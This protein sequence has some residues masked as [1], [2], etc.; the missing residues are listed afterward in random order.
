MTADHNAAAT[1]EERLERLYRSVIEKESLALCGKDAARDFVKE[2]AGSVPPAQGEVLMGNFKDFLT[3][4]GSPY[5]VWK[6]LRGLVEIVDRQGMG[7]LIR[8][9]NLKIIGGGHRDFTDR[10]NHETGAARRVV[11]VAESPYFLILREAMYLRRNGFK[12]HLATLWPISEKLRPLFENH[13][14]SIADTAG[15]IPLLR[16]LLQGLRPDLFHVQCR[17]WAYYLGRM[18]IEN[19]GDAGVVCEFYDITSLFAS[20]E[21]LAAVWSA[22]MADLD[23]GLERYML[24]KADGVLSRFPSWIMAEWAERHE[25]E[26]LY[27]EFQSYPCTEFSDTGGARL[28]NDD[29]VIRLVFAGGL[30]PIDENHPQFLFPEVGMLGAFRSFLEQG[31][32]LDILHNPHMDRTEEEQAFAQY[33]D[34][35]NSYPRFRILNGVPPDRLAAALVPYDFGILLFDYDSSTARLGEFHK[36]GVVG[37]KIFSYLEAG[38]PVLVNTEYEHMAS[39]VTEHGLGLAVHSSDIPRLAETLAA[40]DLDAAAAN[41]EKY[42]SEHG[43]EREIDRLIGFYDR[44]LKEKHNA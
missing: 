11:F 36:R 15:N 28:S 33:H 14:N 27:M 12:V 8:R 23:I 9:H 25:A 38:L 3:K 42:N 24:H 44:I 34:L 29:S 43:M 6:S 30:I 7:G 16:L 2:V 18:C 20:R 31:L 21:D 5:E 17:M 4:R 22:D 41:I 13:F 26:P 10:V 1:D 32:A 39:I 40:F 35:E 19:A 37:T